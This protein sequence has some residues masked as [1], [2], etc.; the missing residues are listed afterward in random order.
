MSS[1][2]EQAIVDADALREAAMKNAESIII[3]KYSEE[4]K[5]AV[6]NL[7][8]QEED[9]DLDMDMEDEPLDDGPPDEPVSDIA[10]DV[11]PAHSVGSSGDGEVD[12][13]RDAVDAAEEAL[14]G[15]SDKLDALENV[16]AAGEDSEVEIDLD[17]L[18]AQLDD[19]GEV[20]ADDMADREEVAADLEEEPPLAENTGDEYDIDP[21]ALEAL[22]QE[23][24]VD[25][26]PKAGG[27]LSYPDEK[28]HHAAE[29]KLAA[30]Q[31]DAVAEENDELRKAMKSVQLENKNL[32]TQNSTTQEKNKK[33]E[34]TIM[35]LKGRFDEINL[36]NARLLYTNKVLSSASLNERQ[37]NKIV[38]A[39]SKA[40][41][42][43]E[44]KV[45]YETLE[46]ATGETQTRAMPKSL[47][48]V[49]QR[50]SSMLVSR[51]RKR[52]ETISESFSDRM[53]KLAG[54]K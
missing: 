29:Q 18:R 24:R 26:D 51:N 34:Q 39:I 3:D 53:Q 52:E 31:D 28:L 27:W 4:V 48:E 38:E 1:M 15:V 44:A 30:A 47:S 46:N 13:L 9:M 54:I 16:A 22:V 25:L 42:I 49:V 23:L 36:S 14:E 10:D 50:S 8:E 19:E 40:D 45:I 2:L 21:D 20:E 43:E 32:Q 12:A 33:L 5:K 11:P 37:K 6:H 17:Q 41:T 7:L 35:H